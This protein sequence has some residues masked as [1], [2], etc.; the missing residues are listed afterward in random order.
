MT[1]LILPPLR[2][3]PSPN[4]SSR[5]GRPIS[6]I[7]MH[8]CEGSYNGSI[9]WF[10]MPRSQVSAHIVLREDGKEA[11]QMVDFANKAWHAG[12][13]NSISIGVEMSGFARKSFGAPEWQNAANICAFLLHKFNLPP[14][15]AKH[16]NGKGFCSH[17]DL[18]AAGGGHTDPTTDNA[19]WEHLCGLVSAAY[20]LTAPATWNGVPA[21][22]PVAPAS[23]VPTPTIRRD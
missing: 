16:G 21:N 12:A 13:F 14:T 9:S 5:N 19:V 2:H 18:G 11:T 10:A 22:V 15:W 23:F 4:F 7:V 3:V 1:D 20:N 6:L 17:Y 8:D